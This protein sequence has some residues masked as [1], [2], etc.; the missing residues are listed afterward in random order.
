M[1]GDG[2]QARK[3]N[4]QNSDILPAVSGLNANV[5]QNK[6]QPYYSGTF[7]FGPTITIWNFYTENIVA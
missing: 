7:L 4:G 2:W 6:I 5:F 1:P 3:F